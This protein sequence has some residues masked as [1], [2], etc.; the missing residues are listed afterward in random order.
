MK[1]RT[2]ISAAVTLMIC[3]IVSGCAS[4]QSATLP[5]SESREAPSHHANLVVPSDFMLELATV[6]DFANWELARNDPQMGGRA[7]PRDSSHRVVE[8]RQ[9]EVL[10]TSNGRPRDYSYTRIRTYSR[11]SR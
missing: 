5:V 1:I 7:L 2:S 9:W 11:D 6:D 4:R 10:G 3:L 8:T